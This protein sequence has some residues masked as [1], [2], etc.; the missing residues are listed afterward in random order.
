M[1]EQHSRNIVNDENLLLY[2]VNDFSIFTGFSCGLKDLDEYIQNDAEAHAEQLLAVTYVLHLK[3]KE[4]V[5]D[6]AAF[7]SLMN[8]SLEI[9]SNRRKKTFR[10]AKHYSSYPALKIGRL[11][12]H[13]EY[14]R[15]NIGTTLL[16]I[17]KNLFLT[18][19][20]TGCRF[21]TVDAYNTKE[22][23]AFYLKNEF[24][25]LTENDKDKAT[26]HM[27]FDLYRMQEKNK[28]QL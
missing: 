26:R 1:I 23:I 8:D 10:R 15:L 19:N 14:Q 7:I 28:A 18:H 4:K 21:I 12:V 25:F 2:P 27:F 5:S 9:N 11:G 22:T 13:E 16:H 24:K 17:V 20:R 3:E 6:P